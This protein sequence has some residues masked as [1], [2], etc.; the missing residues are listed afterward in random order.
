[1][2]CCLPLVAVVLF[3]AT[4]FASSAE[5]IPPAEAAK[6]VGEEVTVLL[7]IESS[8]LR[9]GRCF[10]NSESNF[11]SADNFTLFIDRDAMAK[12]KEA[13][14]DD[15]SSHFRGKT[16]HADGKVAEFRGRPQISLVGPDAIKI[17]EK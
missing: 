11:R 17:V 14:I 7:T 9:D 12:F 6:M 2:R 10:L 4:P 8:S 3:V 13:G 16:V 1:M 5:P 15:P